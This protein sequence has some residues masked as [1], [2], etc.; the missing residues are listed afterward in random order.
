[1]VACEAATWLHGLG[2]EELTIVQPGELPVSRNE[3]FVSSILV[4]SF[5]DAGVTVKLGRRVESVSRP[6]VN[7][8]GPGSSMAAR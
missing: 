4:K 8:A 7:A 3:P 1:V 2:V 5:T 6:S